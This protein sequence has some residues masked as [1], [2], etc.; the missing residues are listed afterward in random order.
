MQ[1][2]ILRAVGMCLIYIICMGIAV[3]AAGI[4]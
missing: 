2:D 3:V 1:L 4:T